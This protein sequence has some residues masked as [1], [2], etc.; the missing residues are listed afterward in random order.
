[1]EYRVPLPSS[2]RMRGE[3]SRT[4]L[5]QRRSCS[6]THYPF[7]SMQRTI[8]FVAAASQSAFAFEVEASQHATPVLHDAN[9]LLGRSHSSVPR[10]RASSHAADWV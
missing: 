6:S 5:G 10:Q 3:L 9:S 7:G 1:M 4:A 2:W 8:A